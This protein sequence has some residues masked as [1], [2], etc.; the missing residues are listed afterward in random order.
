MYT[1]QNNNF[2]R[3]TYF[4]FTSIA[5]MRNNIGVKERLI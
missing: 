4:T 2:S 3:V 5:H 1:L